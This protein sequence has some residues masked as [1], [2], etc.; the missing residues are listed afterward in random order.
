CGSPQRGLDRGLRA[1][2]RQEIQSHLRLP[3]RRDDVDPGGLLT[4]LSVELACQLEP[5]LGAARACLTE[6]VLHRLWDDDARNL[7]VEPHRELVRAHDE[8][9][10]Q[11]RN[12]PAAEQLLEAVEVAEIEERLRHRELRAGIDFLPEALELGLEVVRRGIDR[13]AEEERRGRVD[14]FA[15]EVLAGGQASNGV[16]KSDRVD[17]VDTA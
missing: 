13:Y 15:V 7:V 14:R 8:D 2:G 1:L 5:D 4:G 3:E 12:R 10:D 6:A 16:R 17:L 11:N 9:A